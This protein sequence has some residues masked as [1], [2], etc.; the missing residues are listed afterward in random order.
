MNHQVVEIEN[1]TA[2]AVVPLVFGAEEARKARE[3][4]ERAAAAGMEGASSGTSMV[5]CEVGGGSGLDLEAIQIGRVRLPALASELVAQAI[6]FFD[7]VGHF[8]LHFDTNKRHFL[9]SFLPLLYYFYN[10]FL[11]YILHLYHY[12]LLIASTN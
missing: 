11:N 3:A 5:S 8:L 4:E 1:L 7:Q 2:W 10:I 6:E 9:D 12:F